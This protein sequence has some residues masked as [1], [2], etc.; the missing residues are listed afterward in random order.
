MKVHCSLSQLRWSFPKAALVYKVSWESKSFVSTLPLERVAPCPWRENKGHGEITDTFWWFG[1]E[2]AHTSLPLVN[3]NMV[4][5]WL[6]EQ[7]GMQSQERKGGLMSTESDLCNEVF[8][9]RTQTV[10]H[11][12]SV[13]KGN[14]VEQGGFSLF[15]GETMPLW[16]LEGMGMFMVLRLQHRVTPGQESFILQSYQLWSGSTL[17][18]VRVWGRRSIKR[19]LHRRTW[20]L[21]VDIRSLLNI[22]SG[23]CQLGACEG[24][25]R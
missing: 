16:W 1:P 2:V 12:G 4:P 18:C 8:L 23:I 11:W 13:N 19:E 14:R 7:L 15:C 21:R 22:W 24:Y 6:Q 20:D 3:P 10:F 17:T 9:W 5:A 25:Q